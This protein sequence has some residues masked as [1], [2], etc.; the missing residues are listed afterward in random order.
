MSSGADAGVVGRG[1]RA[2]RRVRTIA[3]RVAKSSY[4]R[5]RVPQLG[6]R[7]TSSTMSV[8]GQVPVV[9]SLTTYGD[10]VAQVGYTVES[11]AAGTVRP[12]RMILW[13]DDPMTFQDLPEPVRRLQ[14]R[15][16]E[17]RLTVNHGPH[18]KYVGALPIVQEWDL[19][20]VTAD[21][22][23]LYPRTW[24]SRLWMAHQ[25]QPHLVHCY[26]AAV[27]Q[28]DGASIAPYTSWPMCTSTRPSLANLATGVSGVIYPRSVCADLLA[29]GT[30]FE[31]ACP[32]ADD[33]WLHWV[34]LQNRVA[35]RQLSRIPR[36]FPTVPGTQDQALMT[37]NLAGSGNDR[38]IA[39]L[40]TLDDV[41]ALAA[42][43]VR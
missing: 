41:S 18:T 11:I 35:V 42:A 27:V 33:I 22:D 34:E 29:R 9:V 14:E 1:R 19:V 23:I 30:A 10:R 4:A 36:H 15:G 12:A 17:V 13:L 3:R 39:G 5:V 25:A 8:L 38:S 24:L 2:G 32:K 43:R 16:L 31:R 26:R 37:H 28:S 7:I 20:L 21:D 40:Y 6:R